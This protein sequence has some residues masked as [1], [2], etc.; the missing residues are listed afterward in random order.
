MLT[1]KSA[2]TRMHSASTHRVIGQSCALA[3]KI[4]RKHIL[5]RR[6]AGGVMHA[7]TLCKNNASNTPIQN[8]LA[9]ALT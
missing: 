5:A 2:H 9:R 1:T 3:Q 7:S 8:A 6:T 4:G